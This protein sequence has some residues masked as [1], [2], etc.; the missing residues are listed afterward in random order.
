MWTLV[1]LAACTEDTRTI[2]GVVKDIWG[3]PV[4]EATVVV[5]GVVE[6]YYT[7]SSGAFSIA[8][9]ATS[10]TLRTEAGASSP[11]AP[12]GPDAALAG[13]TGVRVLVG[14]DGYIKEQEFTPEVEADAAFTPLAFSMYP[15]PEQPGFYAVGRDAY[16]SIGHQRIQMV[17][18]DTMHY[19]GIQDIPEEA[20]PA[21][22]V[23]V[24]FST[25][26]RPSEISQMNL[27]LSRLEFVEKGKV[28]GLFGPESD[29]VNL[30]VAG[31]DSPFDLVGLGTREDY[32]LTTREPLKPGMYAFHA[33]DILH[34]EDERVL[35]SLPKEQVVAFPFEVK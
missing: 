12:A 29:T 1:L 35:Y 2:T 7:D 31:E 5:E 20:L 21:G 18:T 27:H 9:P 34:E 8:L 16:V 3:A 15:Q 32:L 11:E 33:H 4:P 10:L 23:E 22:K 6:R 24:L 19:S 30:W 14:K 17:G 13:R 28:K 26:L 25:R